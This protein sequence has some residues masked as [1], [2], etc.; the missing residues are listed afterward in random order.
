MTSRSAAGHNKNMTIDNVKKLFSVF[1][2][3]NLTFNESKTVKSVS[4]INA[5]GYQVQHKTIKPDP[6]RQPPLQEYPLPPNKKALQRLL[7]F[8]SI[9]RSGFHGFPTR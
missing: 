6:D 4:Q 9:I 8:L 7:G 3:R 1:K 5:L 2:R